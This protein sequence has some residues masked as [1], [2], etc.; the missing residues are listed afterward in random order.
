MLKLTSREANEWPFGAAESP[1]G[2]REVGFGLGFEIYRRGDRV[3]FGHSGGELGYASWI[4]IDPREG[5]AIVALTNNLTH[6][7]GSLAAVLE[8]ILDWQ[9]GEPKFDWS[10]F[11]MEA[12]RRD[13]AQAREDLERVTKPMPGD[14]AKGP[15][16]AALIGEYVS[17]LTGR[18]KIEARG[19]GIVATTGRS[20]EIELRHLRRNIFFGHAVSPL[21]TPMLV[22]FNINALGRTTGL[23]LTWASDPD[24]G[25]EYERVADE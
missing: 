15:D 17:P 5:L 18:L 10:G 6:T 16:P 4:V 3:L 12:G 19:K 25:F 21:R 23:T 7:D 8:P 13:H 24:D 20:Y 2:V 1:Q 9:Y 14:A 11:Y 22:T